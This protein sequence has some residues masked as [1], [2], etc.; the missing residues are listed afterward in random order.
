MLDGWRNGKISQY[1]CS[2]YLSN[3]QEICQT[4]IDQQRESSGRAESSVLQ[5]SQTLEG[6]KLQVNVEDIEAAIEDLVRSYKL[7]S[8]VCS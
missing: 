1:V 3:I 4:E 6:R 2:K 5:R 7:H 8:Q